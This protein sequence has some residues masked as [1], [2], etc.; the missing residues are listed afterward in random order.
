MYHSIVILFVTVKYACRAL[1]VVEDVKL[2]CSVFTVYMQFPFDT[3]ETRSSAVAETVRRFV[4]L[5]I[6]L[7]HSRSFEITL[8]NRACEL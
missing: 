7:S 6:S 1:P 4:S 2:N 8:F 3:V 5:N